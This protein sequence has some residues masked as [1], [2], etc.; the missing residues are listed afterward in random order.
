MNWKYFNVSFE[1][2]LVKNDYGT[3]CYVDLN[4]QHISI[5]TS[6]A[7]HYGVSRLFKPSILEVDSY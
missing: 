4:S 6:M 5:Q 1:F 2:S 7:I 3:C